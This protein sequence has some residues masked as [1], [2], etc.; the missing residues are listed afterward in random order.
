M[1][2]LIYS[3]KILTSQAK[4][5]L[6]IKLNNFDFSCGANTYDLD[7]SDELSNVH[8]RDLRC[9]DP[10]EKLY[11]SMGYEPICFIAQQKMILTSLK[12]FILFV[13][14]VHPVMNLFLN[15]LGCSISKYL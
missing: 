13:H 7:V 11:Y 3:K 9:E 10:V 12:S 5:E 2:R 8:F 1:W 15:N 14:H 4:N 6:E